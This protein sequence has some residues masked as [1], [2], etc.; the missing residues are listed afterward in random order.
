MTL[1]RRGFGIGAAALVASPAIVTSAKAQTVTLKLHHFLPPVSNGHAKLLAP[2]AKKVEAETG[3]QLKIDIFPSM[4]LGG[5]PPQLFDQARDG[6]ADIVWTLPGNTPGRFSRT[7][8]FEL[9]FIASNRAIVNARA[10]AEFAEKHLAEETKEVKLLSFWA[11]DA[12]LIHANKQIRTMDDLKGLKLRNPTRLAGEALKALGATSVGMPVPQVPESLAQR[13]IDGAVIPWEVVP[14]VKVHEL[15]KFH[16]EIPGA[17]TLYTASF[18]LAMNRARYDG[19][20]PN[21]RAALDK[22]LGMAFADMAG[23]MW[24]NEAKTVSA[25]VKSRGNTISTISV[26]EKA[27]W[28]K[29][30]ESVHLAWIEQMKAKGIDGVALI[31]DAKALV[32]KHEKAA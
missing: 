7:E 13:V 20:A 18:F 5:T 11:H 1:S 29:A 28:V 24:D 22:T 2:W 31:A 30:T 25:M 17:P 3:G 12:G 10:C 26:E 16:T 19:L 14:A 23:A 32:A 8:V 6:V 4:Q 21:L 15:T 9:P 27:K